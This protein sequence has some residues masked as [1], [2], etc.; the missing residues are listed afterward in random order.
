MLFTH[1]TLPPFPHKIN[2][3]EDLRRWFLKQESDLFRFR[4][5]RLDG[6]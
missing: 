6:Q 1:K 2:D 4:L 3:R 5:E